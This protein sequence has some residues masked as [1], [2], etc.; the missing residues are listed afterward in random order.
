M[1]LYDLRT[2][3]RVNPMGLIAKAPRFSWKMQSQEK[4]TLQTA[5]E[6][7]VTDEKGKLVWNS[8]K[9]ASDQ[10]VLIPYEGEALAS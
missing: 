6:I 3:Y 1:R 8:G 10:S 4:D 7:H 9:R 2:E 5:Y